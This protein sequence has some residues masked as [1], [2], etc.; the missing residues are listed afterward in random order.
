MD[1]PKTC[2]NPFMMKYA[3]ELD[4]SPA[5]NA[6]GVSYFQSLI[7]ILHYWTVEIGR[8]DIATKISMLSSH[9][10]YSQEGY[11]EVVLHVMG[12]MKL[13]VEYIERIV[14]GIVHTS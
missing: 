13:S 5:F 10:T 7:G 9:F 2:P 11:L 3:P 6:A 8:I 12:Y 4:I 1:S 14:P